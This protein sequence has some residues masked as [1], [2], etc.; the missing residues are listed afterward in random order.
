MWLRDGHVKSAAQASEAG[1]RMAVID[2]KNWLLFGWVLGL[3]KMVG[4][5]YAAFD[6]A[7]MLDS[8]RA[9]SLAQQGLY[10]YQ[11][12]LGSQAGDKPLYSTLCINSLRLALELD[13]ALYKNPDVNTSM[14]LLYYS[15]GENGYAV[16]ILT[17]LPDET[18]LTWPT[19]LQRAAL[20][21]EVKEGVKAL[22]LW[23]RHFDP[24]ALSPPELKNI[25]GMVRSYNVTEFAY[26]LAQIHMA[27]GKK[28]EVLKE[29]TDLVS[30]KSTNGQH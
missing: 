30:K 29:L 3:E 10:L 21:F 15:L 18:M 7:I 26:F 16:T 27:Q 22:W 20:L 1:R 4:Q 17:K 25:E 5:G 12:W 6:H 28:T 8:N 13:P 24:K 9:D 23:R 19:L 14:A 2:P 11:I